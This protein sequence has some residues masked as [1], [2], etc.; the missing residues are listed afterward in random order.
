MTSAH[1][2][3]SR[4]ASRSWR[5]VDLG[6]SES[7]KDA[8]LEGPSAAMSRTSCPRTIKFR[9]SSRTWTASPFGAVSLTSRA[10][11]RILI[12][13]WPRWGGSPRWS[14]FDRKL[15]NAQPARD[16]TRGGTFRKDNASPGLAEQ[17]P[18]HKSHIAKQVF[19]AASFRQAQPLP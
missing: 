7:W 12:A 5:H 3:A 16:R 13:A 9:T 19:L 11:N 15:N 18:P 8:G 4:N 10:K 14:T 1:P 2:L 17:D 6:V